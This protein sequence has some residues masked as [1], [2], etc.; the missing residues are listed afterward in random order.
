MGRSVEEMPT[1]RD[2]TVRT[3]RRKAVR[4]AIDATAIIG[5]AAVVAASLVIT[6]VYQ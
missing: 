5:M 6:V 3:A 1:D 4:S 2:T